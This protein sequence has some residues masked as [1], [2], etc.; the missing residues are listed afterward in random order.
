MRV[1]VGCLSV[2]VMFGLVSRAASADPPTR[3][4][5]VILMTDD[6]GWGDTGYNGHPNLQTPELDALA[7]AGMRFNRFY[8]IGP[9]CSPTRAAQLTGRHY[10]RQGIGTANQGHMFN[11][12]ITLAELAQTQ[13]YRTGHFGKWHLGTLTKDISDSSRGR[14]QNHDDYSAPWHNGYDTAFVTEAKVPTY[15]NDTGSENYNNYGTRYWTGPGTRID[16][17]SLPPEIRGDDSKVV[18]DQ[19]IAFIHDAVNDGQPFLAVNWFH[20]PHKPVKLDPAYR[21]AYSGFSGAELDYYT[22]ISAMD[23]QVGRLRDELRALGIEEE[24][25]VVFTSDNGPEN[26][27]AGA[28]T[29]QSTIGDPDG[30]GGH[31]PIDLRGRKRSLLEGGVRV[32]GIIE[33]PKQIAAGVSDVPVAGS[34]IL[35]TLMDI[36]NLEMPDDRPLD[37]ESIAPLLFDGAIGRTKTIKLQYQGDHAIMDNQYKLVDTGTGWKLY[38]IVNDPE[39]STDI[40]CRDATTEAIGDA[41][42]TEYC[43]WAAEVAASSNGA[44]YSTHIRSTFATAEN[45]T[46]GPLAMSVDTVTN[47]PPDLSPDGIQS[48]NMVRL[49]V[50]RQL[51]TLLTA[52]EVDTTGTPGTYDDTSNMPGGTIA[53]GTVVESFLLHYDPSSLTAANVEVDLDFEN[54]I[55]GVIADDRKLVDSDFLAF[56]DPVFG[57]ALSGRGALEPRDGG[58]T[59]GA[60]GRS[61]ALWFRVGSSGLD[62]IRILTKSSLQPVPE[63]GT[64]IMAV[65]GLSGAGWFGRRLKRRAK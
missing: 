30:P 57:D 53:A 6:Q 4:N 25:L 27:N 13:G 1:V 15:W 48:D 5:I 59:I 2:P 32:P 41:L 47:V 7:E 50:E 22:A 58:W 3:P 54:E 60:D 45:D 61:I 17:T 64:L 35:P 29:E 24:T 55:L 65:L 20:T 11:Q 37:G 18:M 39:E 28:A 34:D 10:N 33:W 38:D 51:A 26:T 9:V 36:W 12:E 56:R 43:A 16:T 46:G 8:S 31:A 44:D 19:T 40:Y 63:P 23:A 52:L 21:D 14:P 42:G 62:Q 49:I